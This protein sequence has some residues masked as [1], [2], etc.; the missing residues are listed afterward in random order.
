MKQS[1]Q[2]NKRW[3]LTFFTQSNNNKIPFNFFTS[4]VL[5]KVV[6]E[7]VP[8]EELYTGKLFQAVL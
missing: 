2:F 8:S 4:K 6:V 5:E 3:Y 7:T 1:L